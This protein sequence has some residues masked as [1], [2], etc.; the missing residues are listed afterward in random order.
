MKLKTISIAA[1]AALSFGQAMAGSGTTAANT[2]LVLLVGDE[3]HSYL[4]DTGIA[5]SDLAAGTV[6]TTLQLTNWSS[7]NFA[8]TKPFDGISSG[9]RWALQG[10][11][12][13]G[14][15]ATTQWML[16]GTPTATT[17]GSFNMGVQNSAIKNDA[18]SAAANDSLNVQPLLASGKNVAVNGDASGAFVTDTVFNYAYGGNLNSQAV[19]T[20]NN[21]ADLYKLLPTKNSKGL[22]ANTGVVAFSNTGE[23]ATLNTTAG[24]LSFSAVSAVPEPGSYALL[25][26]GLACVGFV[27]RRRSV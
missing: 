26:A 6:N 12:Y 2:T 1:L 9:V 5:F 15:I 19:S 11:A 16:G 17:D 24:T 10:V 14:T 18:A 3:Q 27:A 22:Y 7:F 21:V 20:G 23:V 13:N 4:Y 25:L 8:A